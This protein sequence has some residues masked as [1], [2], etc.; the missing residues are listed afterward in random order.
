MTTQDDMVST[1]REA[2]LVMD[3]QTEI[4]RNYVND[5]ARYLAR[6]NSVLEA[7]RQAAVL[8]IFVR[9]AF[10]Q[11]YPEVSPGN[12]RFSAIKS[13]RRLL[14]R[15]AD[16]AIHPDLDLRSDDIVVT[17]HRVNAFWATDLDQILRANQINNLVLCGVATSG[18]VLSTIR[19][20]ADQDYQLTVLADCCAD[21]DAE[22]HEVLTTKVFR[23]QARVRSAA[24][25]IEELRTG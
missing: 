2:F 13:E 22:V 20:A 17:K 8:P 12:R 24:A 10:R 5:Y 18:V 23:G 14:D 4:V 9:A 3:L 1:Y 21:R 25:Y 11:G 7:S 19:S 16:A 15:S 6:V